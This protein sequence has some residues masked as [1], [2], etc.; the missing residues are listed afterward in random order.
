VKLLKTAGLCFKLADVIIGCYPTSC[1]LTQVYP[2]CLIP[3]ESNEQELRH[4]I[5]DSPWDGSA[6]I[7][8]MP[9]AVAQRGELAGG[10]L[11]LD[12]RGE[13]QSGEMRVGV[14]QQYNGRH[15][16]VENGQ[17]GVLLAYAKPTLRRRWR[18]IVAIAGSG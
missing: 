8:M 4:F 11:M 10:M 12:D 7:G 2:C 3:I 5:R 9:E 13:A 17:V 14:G 1:L 6:V 16:Q 18:L 15:H